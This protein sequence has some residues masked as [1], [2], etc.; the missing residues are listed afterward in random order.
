[1]VCCNVES[2][3]Q[4]QTMLRGL[5]VDLMQV[6]CML[7]N[8]IDIANKQ[9]NI[10]L[11]CHNVTI[12]TI[13]SDDNRIWDQCLAI[14]VCIFYVFYRLQQTIS[15]HWFNSCQFRGDDDV[16]IEHSPV[17]SKAGDNQ[18][19]IHR[20]RKHGRVN[21]CYGISHQTGGRCQIVDWWKWNDCKRS[22]SLPIFRFRINIHRNDLTAHFSTLAH[23]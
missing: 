15:Q 4:N 6:P 20:E 1:M 7:N 3:R 21:R 12:T 13:C 16:T 9:Q 18:W 11:A 19:W 22:Q 5:I 14:P 2:N 23:S 8:A 17:S 10:V